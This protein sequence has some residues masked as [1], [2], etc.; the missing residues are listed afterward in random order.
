MRPVKTFVFSSD[1]PVVILQSLARVRERMMVI[2]MT[3]ISHLVFTN[4]AVLSVNI[5]NKQPNIADRTEKSHETTNCRGVEF[6][7]GEGF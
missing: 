3:I 1:H 6:G 4:T 2:K 5:I 7:Q